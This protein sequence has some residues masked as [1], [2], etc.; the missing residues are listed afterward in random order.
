MLGAMDDAADDLDNFR[1]HS[2]TLRA[3]RDAVRELIEAADDECSEMHDAGCKFYNC[4]INECPTCAYPRLKRL[5]AALSRV[6]P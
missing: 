1:M 3:A 5:R 6:Q 4:P 2:E